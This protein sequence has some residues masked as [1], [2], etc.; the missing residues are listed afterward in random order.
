MRILLTNCYSRHNKGDAAIVSVMIEELQKIDRNIQLS[1][2]TMDDIQEDRYFE[3]IS[4]YSSFFFE[5]I[6]RYKNSVDRVC[7]FLYVIVISFVWAFAK[8]ATG[9]SISYGMSIELKNVLEQFANADLVIGVGGGYLIGSKSIQGTVTLLLHLHNILIAKILHKPFI[10]YSQSIGPF[11]NR[12]QAIYTAWVLNKTDEIIARE[13]I[14]V[15]YLHEIGVRDALVYKSV[16]AAFLLK[17][18]NADKMKKVLRKNRVSFSR[19]KI[20][21]TVKRLPETK[22]LVFEQSLA[23]CLDMILSRSNDQIIF[24]PHSTSVIHND[25]D[26]QVIER[27]RRRMNFAS[28]VVVLQ[29]EFSCKEIKSLFSYADIVIATRMHSAIFALTNYVPTIAIAYEH[30]TTGIMSEL[31]LQ[32]WTFPVANLSSKKLF[33]LVMRLKMENGVYKVKLRQVM[34]SYVQKAASTMLVVKKHLKKQGFISDKYIRAYGFGGE[35]NID[36]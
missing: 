25:D 17:G 12:L 7:M 18:V 1:I 2:S 20:M 24:V 21:V 10:L 16:D 35:I 23:E 26:R 15:G 27:I 32:R 5:A 6:Y 30:K 34:P 31:R 19:P 13:K 29:N 33:D 28:R 11:P 22:V 8:I 3:K 14:T 4:L 9:K 36:Y